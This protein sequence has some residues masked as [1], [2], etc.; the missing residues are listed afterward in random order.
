MRNPLLSLWRTYQ[1]SGPR[2]AALLL[3]FYCERVRVSVVGPGRECPIC[4]WE[5]PEFQPL[6]YPA[7]MKWRRRA[8]CPRCG[9]LERHR[10]L[11]F[12]YSDY[13]RTCRQSPRVL[14]FAPEE[15]FRPLFECRSSRYLR[16]DYSGGRGDLRLDLDDLGL[17]GDS[18][19]LVV[20]TSVFSCV[21]DHRRAVHNLHRILTAGGTALLCDPVDPEGKT[22]EWGATCFGVR[23]SFGSR[24]LAEMFSPF[25]ARLVPILDLVPE[26]DRAR[27]GVYGDDFGLIRLDKCSE[28]EKKGLVRSPAL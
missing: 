4:R 10:R 13:F 17:R 7:E 3:K 9:S 26:C 22:N 19:D 14:H 12:A 2:G 5:G 6:V 11:W 23:R 1:G 21:P 18:I 20:A 27:F 25:A 24:D 15:C 8:A 16:S 28:Y